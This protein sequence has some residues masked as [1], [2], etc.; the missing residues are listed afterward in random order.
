M[1][2]LSYQGYEM[3]QKSQE[4]KITESILEE[5]INKMTDESHAEEPIIVKIRN[6]NKSWLKKLWN[7]A[8]P[9]RKNNFWRRLKNKKIVKFIMG[10]GLRQ[11]KNFLKDKISEKSDQD[12]KLDELERVISRELKKL[13]EENKSDQR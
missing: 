5:I 12:K 9:L 1:A 3:Y 13:D 4:N 8:R 2:Y 10:I 11:M 7:K 6:K